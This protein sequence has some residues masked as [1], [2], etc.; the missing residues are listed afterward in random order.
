MLWEE[1]PRIPEMKEGWYGRAE[2]ERDMGGHFSVPALPISHSWATFRVI[3]KSKC[4]IGRQS[5]PILFFTTFLLFCI[6][7]RVCEHQEV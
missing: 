4:E 3:E 1:V 5:L 7:Q 6:F 2:M